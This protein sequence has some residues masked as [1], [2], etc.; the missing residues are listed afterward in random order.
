MTITINAAENMEVF[1]AIPSRDHAI[2]DWQNTKNALK[3]LIELEREKRA[4]LY[5]NLFPNN[6]DT[7]ETVDLPNGYKFKAKGTLNYKLEFSTKE[8]GAKNLDAAIDAIEKIGNEGTFIAERLV[9]WKPELS[10]SEYKALAADSPIKKI[11]D[12]VLTITPGSPE[13]ELVPPK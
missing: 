7:T 10:V 2:I 4:T 5:K 9:K 13:L 6:V 1:N 8:D 11:I 12:G 3:A